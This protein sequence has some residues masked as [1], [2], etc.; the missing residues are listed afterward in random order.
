MY[1][2]YINLSTP[3][4]AFVLWEW[5]MQAKMFLE[6]IHKLM[7]TGSVHNKKKTVLWGCNEDTNVKALDQVTMLKYAT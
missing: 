2:C 6:L 5:E 3:F 7:D 1:F 4:S